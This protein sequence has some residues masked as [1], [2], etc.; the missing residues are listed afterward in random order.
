MIGAFADEWDP[1]YMPP[2]T[3]TPTQA[4]RATRGTPE[5]VA[6]GI[7]IS[8]QSDAELHLPA[9]HLGLPR[10]LKESIAPKG[11]HVQNRPTLQGRTRPLPPIQNH[12]KPLTQRCLPSM[13]HL[14]RPIVWSLLQHPRMMFL[15]R[16]L[17]IL[18]GGASMV[19]IRSIGTQRF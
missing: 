17:M 18:T 4:A 16:F 12:L 8:S 7:V 13:L 9:H 14:M 19:C 10:V 5:I 1:K 3:Q 2:L 6:S 15:H 11:H